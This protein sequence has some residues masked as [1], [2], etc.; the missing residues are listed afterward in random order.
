MVNVAGPATIIGLMNSAGGTLVID[1]VKIAAKIGGGVGMGV[2]GG[3]GV[4][5]TIT[6]SDAAVA[7]GLPLVSPL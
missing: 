7:A 3:V 1:A 2:G 5:V 6:V 4:A